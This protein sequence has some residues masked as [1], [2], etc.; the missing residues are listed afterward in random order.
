MTD[1][2]KPPGAPGVDAASA[3]EAT[4]AAE[5]TQATEAATFEVAPAA[6]EAAP[7]ATD[8]LQLAIEEV[9]FEARDNEFVDQVNAA[10]D[11]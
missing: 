8:P 6:V 4:E 3:V 5:S 10:L 2:I 7:P 9:A 1:P 11:S